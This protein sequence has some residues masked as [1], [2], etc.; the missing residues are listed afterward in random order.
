[1]VHAG[2]G[3]IAHVRG[4]VIPSPARA[5]LAAL[6]KSRS[7]AAAATAARD[8][9]KKGRRTAAL[10]N[11]RSMDAG[12]Y[13]PGREMGDGGERE[14]ETRRDDSARAGRRPARARRE[15]DKRATVHARFS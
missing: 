13:F 14:R 8:R 6:C 7:Q 1:M 15:W 12:H 11:G 2:E 5:R 9:R 10:V 3:L 4:D